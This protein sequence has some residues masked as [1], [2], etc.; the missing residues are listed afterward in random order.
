MGEFIT[1]QANNNRTPMLNDAKH[2]VVQLTPEQTKTLEA[3]IK[4]IRDAWVGERGASGDAIIQAY[5]KAHAD[6]AAGR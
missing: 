3:K 2:K 5:Q 1:G 4:P 6:S